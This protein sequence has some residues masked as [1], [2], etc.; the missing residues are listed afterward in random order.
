MVGWT[1]SADEK[2]NACLVF[3]GKPFGLYPL[4]Q[5]WNRW[6]N[7][8]KMSHKQSVLEDINYTELI[9]CYVQHQACNLWD[10]INKKVWSLIIGMQCL[11][12]CQFFT[13][14][15]LCTCVHKVISYYRC[16]KHIQLPSCSAYTATL[17]MKAV[18]NA[19]KLVYISYFQ[20]RS[21]WLESLRTLRSVNRSK[22]KV[23][24]WTFWTGGWGQQ[25]ASRILE[26]I[27]FKKGL[28]YHASIILSLPVC[29]PK[30][31]RLIQNCNFAYCL[32]GC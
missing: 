3:V 2:T 10:F 4:W 17:C 1:C 32:Y 28:C 12:M 25:I 29:Y 5:P 30:I 9:Q 16:F 22:S 8:I 21:S 11:S 7:S 26:Q 6:E 31:Y 18:L 14:Y 13:I 27:K 23:V 15:S 20:Q 19:L 24:Q